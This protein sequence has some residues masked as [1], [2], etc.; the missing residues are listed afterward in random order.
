M[1]RD[2]GVSAIPTGPYEET[3][4]VIIASQIGAFDWEIENS[5]ELVG[6]NTKGHRHCFRSQHRLTWL[7]FNRLENCVKTPNRERIVKRLWS[8]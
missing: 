5:H 2:V 3:P 6:K 1:N 4:S 7:S 8:Q